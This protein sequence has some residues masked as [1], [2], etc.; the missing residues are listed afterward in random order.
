MGCMGRF[1][2]YRAQLSSHVYTDHYR[3]FS[4]GVFKKSA[5]IC[6]ISEI[7]VRKAYPLK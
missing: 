7:C 6:E 1:A 3:F 5:P 4:K 2:R